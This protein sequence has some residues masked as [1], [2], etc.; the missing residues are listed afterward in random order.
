MQVYNIFLLML[1][2]VFILLCGIFAKKASKGHTLRTVAGL[3]AP[4]II[5]TVM[6][7][8]VE[9]IVAGYAETGELLSGDLAVKNYLFPR[10]AFT[11]IIL[12]FILLTAASAFLLKSRERIN[13]TLAFAGCS[14]FVI[15]A[16]A[17]LICISSS[18]KFS[19]HGQVIIPVALI[20]AIS[21]IFAL[22]DTLLDT[23]KKHRKLIL[24]AV[25][26]VY[27]AVDAFI[28]WFAQSAGLG[29]ELEYA[30]GHMTVGAIA[31]IVIGIVLIAGPALIS[32]F[33]LVA[34]SI[35]GYKY[36]KKDKLPLNKG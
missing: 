19:E 32:L 10:H 35:G 24:Y 28:L 12:L 15:I 1:S 33:S 26:L 27:C 21:E 8:V 22:A 17:V 7:F 3:A 30:G 11:V 25:N 5:L 4:F 13:P 23:D 34:K 16:A 18:E 14:V 9:M 29:E 31:V 2:A 6:C 36:A 20:F